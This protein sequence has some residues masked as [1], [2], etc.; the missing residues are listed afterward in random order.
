MSMMASQI[1]AVSMVC[2]TVCSGSDQ[3]KHQS[4]VSLAF[5]RV[6]HRWPVNSP[7]KGP[8]TWKMFPFD[9]VIMFL[10]QANYEAYTCIVNTAEEVDGVIIENGMSSW[11]CLQME[12]YS[13][14]LALCQGNPLVTRGFP[15]QSPV[16]WSFGVFFDQ[17][18]NKW[19]SKQSRRRWFEMP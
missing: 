3:R 9:Y 10:S 19:L 6:I 15:S 8:I 14:L 11:W 7:H 16:T 2:P 5:V 4:S 13:T 18:L 12:T 1:T 17:H